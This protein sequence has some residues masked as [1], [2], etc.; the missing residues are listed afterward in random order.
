MLS[1]H[2]PLLRTRV[3]RDVNTADAYIDRLVLNLYCGP[4]PVD[5]WVDDLD[6]GP[7]RPKPAAA[8]PRTR[9]AAAGTTTGGVKPTDPASRT[10]TV[11]QQSGLLKVDGRPFFPRIIRHSGTPLFALRMAGFNTI[12]FP[13]DA[14]PEAIEEAARNGFLVVPS[15]PPLEPRGGLATGEADAQYVRQEADRYA[16]LF[17]KFLA[18]D[19]VLFWDLGG[20]HRSEDVAAVEASA[21]FVRD[22]PTRAARIG[23]DVW[24][25]FQAYSLY[26]DVVGAHRWPLFSSL[27]LYQLPRVADPA[28]AAHGH[29]RARVLDLGADA[30]AGLVRDAAR[31]PPGHGRV[32]RPD[33]PA[34]GADPAAGVHQHRRAAAAGSASGPTG[35]WRTATTAGTGCRAWRS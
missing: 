35:S 30:H 31:R 21:R 19:S 15:V 20:G 27:E 28:A 18:G 17:Q 14:T 8:A 1:K 13:P 10:R 32:R 5:V 12:W 26:L 23:A 9:P 25:G 6:I 3:G 16:T 34:P 2:L 11:V 7:V 33:R 24:D 29:A 22:L 4:G